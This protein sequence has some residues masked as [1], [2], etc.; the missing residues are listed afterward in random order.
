M[1]QGFKSRIKYS[2][3]FMVIIIEVFL[4]YIVPRQVNEDLIMIQAFSK[5]GFLEH[6]DHIE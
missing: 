5:N 3:K 6:S 1:H 4:K 2:F